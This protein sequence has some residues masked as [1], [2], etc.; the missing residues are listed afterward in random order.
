MNC[1]S[2]KVYVTSSILALSKSKIEHLQVKSSPCRVRSRDAKSSSLT[3]SKIHS[4]LET[5]F[6]PV[7]LYTSHIAAKATH[8]LV[9]S[10]GSITQ[11][12]FFD[13]QESVALYTC[14]KAMHRSCLQHYKSDATTYS[15][16]NLSLQKVRWLTW[17]QRQPHVD[18]K[19]GQKAASE[20]ELSK[21]TTEESQ[22]AATKHGKLRIGWIAAS[23][24][25][26]IA[27]PPT[28]QQ[29]QSPWISRFRSI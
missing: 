7:G 9:T 6:P 14:Q 20:R 13:L 24:I 8:Q 29:Q 1:K 28:N 23:L 16:T 12:K 25:W 18:S 5:N 19:A 2:N 15:T 22:T 4:K 21:L 17:K 27:P 11:R 26:T 10:E 3:G